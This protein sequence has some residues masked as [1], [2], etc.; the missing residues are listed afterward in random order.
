MKGFS[1]L[2]ML[3]CLGLMTMF[4]SGVIF[5]LGYWQAHA[6][7]V[8]QTAWLQQDILLSQQQARVL[9]QEVILC[10]SSGGVRCGNHW[11]AGRLAYTVVS[12]RHQKL[13]FHRLR[14]KKAQWRW[15]SSLGKNDRLI[16]RPTGDNLGQQ[17]SFYYCPEHYKK[18]FIRRIIINQLGR[19]YERLGQVRDC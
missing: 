8:S 14:L 6:Q 18:T 19:V 1:L 13:F 2:E 15:Q 9:G 16:F 5:G 7:M 12:N 3:V 10:P 11:S 17:G 4:G